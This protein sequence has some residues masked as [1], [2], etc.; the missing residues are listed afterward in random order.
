MS[1]STI[2]TTIETDVANIVKTAEGDAATWFKSFT[3]VLEADVAAAWNQFK[4]V[5]MG[6]IVGVEQIGVSALASGSGVTFD[7]LAAAAG[8]LIA[9]AASQGVTIAKGT[10]TTVIQQAVSS[11]GVAVTPAKTS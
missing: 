4:P 11:I 10:A 7:K 8:G 3:P 1:L 5:I 2:L 9:A 6:L